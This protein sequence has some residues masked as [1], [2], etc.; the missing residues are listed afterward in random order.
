MAE[1]KIKPLQALIG[2]VLVLG[3][4][5][6]FFGGGLEKQT[7]SN[8]Q[9]IQKQSAVTMQEIENKVAADAVEKYEIARRNYLSETEVSAM[10]ASAIDVCVQAGLV[11]AAYLQAKDEAHYQ[12][13]KR[14]E[15][16][17]CE[18]AGLRR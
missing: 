7:A 2:G 5:W 18:R 3:G 16:V 13:W 11:T 1:Q 4:V 8:M 14:K 9:E 17:D 15:S 10:R 6:Y 12:E